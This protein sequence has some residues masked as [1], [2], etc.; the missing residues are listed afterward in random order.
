M[1]RRHL[2]GL[3]PHL[4]HE[5]KRTLR[6]DQKMKQDIERILICDQRKQIQACDILYGIFM[7]YATGQFS[8]AQH[9]VSE[10]FNLTEH[11]MMTAG[12]GF[13]A[14]RICSIQHSAVCKDDTCREKHPVAV[15]PCSAAHS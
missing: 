15:R 14:L 12:K 4:T 5:C 7:S 11:L 9:F 2:Q 13:P 6:T 1:Q 8:I 10:L 3:H